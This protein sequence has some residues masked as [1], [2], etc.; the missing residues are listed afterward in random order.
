MPHEDVD[1]QIRIVGVSQV[2]HPRPHA[3]FVLWI[4]DTEN[5]ENCTLNLG[6]Q[7]VGIKGAWW[8]SLREKAQNLLNCKYVYAHAEAGR[9]LVTN[10]LIFRA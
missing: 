1:S 2:H 3:V 5:G 8:R 4:G 6:R 10:G 9:L 7:V